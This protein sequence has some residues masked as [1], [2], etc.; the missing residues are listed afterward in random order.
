M[1]QMSSP[2]TDALDLVITNALIVDH[3]GITK[4]D[5]GVSD[6]KIKGIG[7]AGNPD[8]QDGVTPGMIIGDRT[9][10]IAGENLII[11]AGAVDAHVHYICPQQIWEAIASGCDTFHPFFTLFFLISNPRRSD[12]IHRWRHGS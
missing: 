8:V 9:E 7:K 2:V 3:S 6:G 4:A 5:I 1:G 10:V 12:D 11:T